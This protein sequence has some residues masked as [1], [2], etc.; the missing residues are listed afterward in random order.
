MPAALFGGG[1]LF[2]QVR[3]APAMPIV[4]VVVVGLLVVFC[5]VRA[6]KKCTVGI[7]RGS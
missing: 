6:G 5:S 3:S 1:V 4:V 7:K 2:F